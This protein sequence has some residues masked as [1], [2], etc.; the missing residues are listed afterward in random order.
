MRR[1]RR[2]DVLRAAAVLLVMSAHSTPT[3]WLGRSGWIGV[4]LF[5]VLSG[6]LISGLLFAEYRASGRIDAGRFLI[7]RGFKIYPSFYAFLA[8]TVI[9]EA[10]RGRMI[11]GGQLLAETLF[12][13]NY[14]PRFWGHTWSLAVEEHF[15]LL[16]PFALVA[17]LRFGKTPGAS[18]RRLPLLIV[19]LAGAILVG[20]TY[21]A[22]RGFWVYSHTHCRADALAAGVFLGWFWHFRARET[23]AWAERF[24]WAV[25]LI[26][27]GVV[28]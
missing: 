20:R 5:F 16:L 14:G 24:R 8:I 3:P 22:S 28:L 13:Q 15:Y 18:L 1:S 27:S 2:L 26:S 4:D 19:F 9:V 23:R 21:T 17:L 7:R 10:F 6:F 25:L 11:T 12:V